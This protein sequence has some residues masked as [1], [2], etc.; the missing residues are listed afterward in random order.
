MM[1]SGAILITGAAGFIGSAL[2]RRLTAAGERIVGLD[3]V[4]ADDALFPCVVND[5]RDVQAIDDLCTAFDVDRI[6]HAGGIS[7]RSVER[8]D[9]NA[10]IA[11]NVTGTAAIFEAARR[12]G[13][14]RVVL[15]SSGSVYGSSDRDPVTEDSPLI[16]VNSYGASKV[17]SEAIMH[18]YAAESGVDGIALRIFQAFGP[19]RRTRCSIRTMVEAALE[20][21]VATIAYREDARCQYIYIDDVVEA[22][23]AALCAGPTPQRVYNISGGTSLTL[24]EVANIAAKILPGLSV[25]FGDDPLSWEY[26]LKQIDISAAKRDLGYVPKV[27]LAEGIAAY[28]GRLRSR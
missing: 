23:F 13:M 5:V 18:A 20:G 4:P 14:R 22:L 10:P 12:H 26:R 25:Q 27:G 7:G 15:C 28:V 1:S 9:K 6:V 3:L 19:G 24:T 17:G 2:G 11:V 8:R 21:Q 16:P